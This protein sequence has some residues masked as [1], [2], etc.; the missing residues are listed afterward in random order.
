[1][2]PEAALAGTIGLDARSLHLRRLALKALEGGGRGHIGSTLSLIEIMRVLYD[3]VL[4]FDPKT[5]DWAERD[6]CLLSK[7]HGCIALYAMLADKGFFPMDRLATFCRTGSILGGHPE[8]GK[9]PRS[10]EHTSELQSH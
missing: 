5:P 9:V 6:R 8:H 1:M 4:R 2:S 7:G 3:E 10:E